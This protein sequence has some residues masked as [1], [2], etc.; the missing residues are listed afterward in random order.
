MWYGQKDRYINQWKIITQKQ[1]HKICPTD[2]FTKVQKQLIGGRTV[3]LTNDAKA[4]GCPLA[5]GGWWEEA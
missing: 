2:F 4:I 3:F 1:T 5:V